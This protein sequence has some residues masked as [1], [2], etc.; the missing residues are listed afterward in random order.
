[1]HQRIFSPAILE[2]LEIL[3]FIYEGDYQGQTITADE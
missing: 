2:L 1:M 3:K